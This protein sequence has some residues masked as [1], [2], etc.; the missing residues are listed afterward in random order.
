MSIFAEASIESILEA[1]CSPLGRPL[2]HPG[3]TFLTYKMKAFDWMTP[4][5]FA[6]L[7][8]SSV[9]LSLSRLYFLIKYPSWIHSKIQDMN[10]G[11]SF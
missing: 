11:K 4:C 6:G 2:P 9:I 3:V 5:Y 10:D 8:K 1:Q 7:F